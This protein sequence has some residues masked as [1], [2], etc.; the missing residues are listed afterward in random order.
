MNAST[1]NIDILESTLR[2]RGILLKI[3]LTDRTTKKNIIWAT[4]SYEN[5]GKDFLAEKQIKSELVTGRY[6]LLIQPRAAKSLVE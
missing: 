1:H 5:Y 3:L 6:G 4:D 2:R